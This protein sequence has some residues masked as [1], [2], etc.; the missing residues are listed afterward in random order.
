MLKREAQQTLKIRGVIGTIR[1]MTVFPFVRLWYL[2]LSRSKTIKVKGEADLVFD[3][4]YGLDTNGSIRLSNLDIEN[5]NWIYGIPYEPTCYVDFG[6]VLAKLAELEIAYEQFIFID[7][8]SG[9]GRPVLMASALPFEKIIGIEFSKK[10]TSIANNNLSLYPKEEKKCKDIEFICTD[11]AEYCLPEE[12]LVLYFFNP[13]RE[14]VMSQVINNVAA[15]FRK[16][17]RRIVVLYFNPVHAYLWDSAG[18]LTKVR[19]APELCIYDTR[20]PEMDTK[21]GS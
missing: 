3:S 17:P 13:F 10:L 19:A 20:N 16:K 18:F 15:S 2:V 4:R 11:A 21:N 6:Q 7:F 14:P 12:P 9:K 1:G 8:G 5:K